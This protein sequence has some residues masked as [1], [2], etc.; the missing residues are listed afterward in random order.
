MSDPEAD[1]YNLRIGT[2][3]FAGLYHFTT[4][5]LLVETAQATLEMGSDI[6]KFDMSSDFG[7]KYNLTLAPSITNLISLARDEPSC[8]R[9]LDMPFRH[10]VIWAYAFTSGW[11]ANGWSAQQRQ[12]E[13]AEVYTLTRYLLTNYTSSG[14][15]FYLGHWEGDWHLL[16]SFNA[17]TN[18]SPVAIQGMRE[19][20]NTRQAAVDDAKR[21]TPHAGVEVYLYTEVNRVLDAMK[22]PASVSQRVINA[23]VP[24]VTNLDFVSWSSYDGMNLSSTALTS[25]LNYME[26]MLPTNKASITS[27]KRI[28][29]GEYGWGGTLSPTAQEPLTRAYVNRLLQWGC[30]FALFWEIYNNEPGHQYQ[31]IDPSGAKNACYDF[32]QR[33]LNRAR[34][35][36]AQF[37]QDH[38]RL[39]DEVEFR[40]LVTAWLGQPLAPPVSLSW[41]GTGAG[42]VTTPAVTVTAVLTQ[43]IYG[44]PWADVILYWGTTDGGTNSGNW[45][46]AI[47]LGQNSR[48]GPSPFTATLTTVSAGTPYYYRFLATNGTAAAWSPPGTSVRPKTVLDPRSYGFRMQIKASGYN[49]SEVLTNFPLLVLF[50]PSTTGF[51]Y[52][53]FASTNAGDLRFTD[54][55]GIELSHEI[56]EWN[57]NGVSSVWV[58]APTLGSS[59]SV[60]WAY[61]GNPNAAS[62]PSWTTNGS[63]WSEGFEAVWHLRESGLPYADSVQRHPLTIGTSPKRATNGVVGHGQQFD[64]LN[65]YL[66]T[67]GFGLANQLSLSGWVY[68]DPAGTSIQTLMSTKAGGYSTDGLA[69]YANSWQTQDHKLLLETGNGTDGLTAATSAGPVIP[70]GWHLLEAEVDRDAASAVLYV[71]GVAATAPT[72]IVTDFNSSSDLNVGQFID[73]NFRLRGTLDELR[74]SN[75]ICFSNWV[76]ASW[77]TVANPTSFVMYAPVE[78][79]PRQPH[80]DASVSPEGILLEWP[81]WATSFNLWSA[82]DLSISNQWVLLNASAQQSNGSWLLTLPTDRQSRFFELR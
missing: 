66:K 7:S 58:Q 80:L 11:W 64:G 77:M 47:S 59:N 14:K 72:K 71:D 60:I 18:P 51:A 43:G 28:W 15:A 38:G 75:Q 42:S 56:D 45:D 46:H 69:L 55:G 37:R 35:A 1:A 48:F 5:T 34:L 30:R 62:A 25:T 65:S 17:T 23:V 26:S 12:A 22:G 33:F 36:V 52:P 21:D 79:P 54:A 67:A 41:T 44:E 70:G 19:W 63:V 39:P 81:A 57:P 76:W 78:T 50:G 74:I 20:L 9:A 40:G 73:G 16:G 4:N 13:Y 8:R 2:Q 68:L 24:F 61:W 10:Y 31:L 49:R 32:H 29:V 53:Q 6:L 27:G 82:L 3:T